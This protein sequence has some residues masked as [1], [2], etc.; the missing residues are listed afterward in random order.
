MIV[1]GTPPDRTP[2]NAPE[3][4]TTLRSVIGELLAERSVSRVAHESDVPGKL[5]SLGIRPCAEP[6]APSP[7]L[8]VHRSD[9]AARTDYYFFYNQGVVSPENEP[10]TLFEPATG[11]PVDREF[12]L[13]GRGRPYLLDAWSGK[14]HPLVNYASNGERVTLRIRLARDNAALI[15]LGE[16]PNRFGVPPPEVHATKTSAED[17]VMDP[18]GVAIRASKAG[19]YTTSLSN[20]RTVRSVIGSVPSAI[21]LTRAAWHLAVE[22]WQPA[23]PYATTF[24]VAAAETRKAK[25]ELDL[26]EL[27]PWPEIPALRNVSGLGTYTT[28]VDLP[29]KWTAANGA[30]LSLGEVFDTFTLTVNGRAVPIDQLAA[31]GDIGPY[32]KAGRNTIAVRVATTLNNRLAEIDD[33]VAN[34]GL[35]QPYGLVG[36]VVL[37]PY[38]QAIVWS[39]AGR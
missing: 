14:I 24:G 33:D 29:A 30:R 9:A 7:V 1:V 6:G 20:G 36:P 39:K 2:G 18:G 10:R 25:A 26:K 23:N 16:D 21:D 11:E 19:T 17:A 22:D 28:R 15:A 35:A 37:T 38:G 31:E 4:D 8:S 27:K 32:L 13:E 34:R 3:A 12:S 5:R